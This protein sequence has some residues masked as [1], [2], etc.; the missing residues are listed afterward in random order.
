MHRTVSRCNYCYGEC[1]KADKAIA[2]RPNIDVNR[3]MRL[4]TRDGPNGPGGGASFF[5]GTTYNIVNRSR[6]GKRAVA[7]M[8]REI[9]PS[10]TLRVVMSEKMIF[11]IT[12]V[13]NEFQYS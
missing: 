2:L 5:N 13:V 7:N 4:V 8:T 12:T 9:R 11:F 6:Y 3:V 10:R 1:T